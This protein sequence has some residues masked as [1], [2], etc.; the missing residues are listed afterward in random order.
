M[1]VS[2]MTDMADKADATDAL[3]PEETLAPP[4]PPKRT[5][6]IVS[7]ALSQEYAYEDLGKSHRA[8]P[9][10]LTLTLTGLAGLRVVELPRECLP[11]GLLDRV[12]V[13][14][15]GSGDA[16]AEPL[17]PLAVHV[18][19]LTGNV[20]LQAFMTPGQSGRAMTAWVGDGTF[21]SQD[22]AMEDMGQ[23][24]DATG[25]EMRGGRAFPCSHI[26]AVAI[27]VKAPCPDT[28]H[29]VFHCINAMARTALVGDPADIAPPKGQPM[30]KGLLFPPI[31]ESKRATTLAHCRIPPPASVAPPKDVDA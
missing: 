29:V 20:V 14:A 9:T 23:F 17:P 26:V 2:I 15:V 5:C 30:P 27:E 1:V 31:P 6:N 16:P 22:D 24:K 12:E 10:C 13:R 25:H 19:K 18:H 8:V 4:P 11:F 21:S 28:L 3:G 7:F